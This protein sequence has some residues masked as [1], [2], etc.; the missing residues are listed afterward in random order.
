[1][2]GT[3]IQNNLS[4]SSMDLKQLSTLFNI[5]LTVWPKNWQLYATKC[6]NMHF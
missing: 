6:Q 5:Q 4:N 2:Q 1:M 3:T